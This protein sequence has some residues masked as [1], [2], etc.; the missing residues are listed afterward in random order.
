MPVAQFASL[1]CFLSSARHAPGLVRLSF[2]AVIRHNV[3][4]DRTDGDW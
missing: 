1:S 3:Y 4:D 2:L